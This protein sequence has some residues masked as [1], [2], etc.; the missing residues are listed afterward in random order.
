MDSALMTPTFGAAAAALLAVAAAAAAIIY[1]Q[2]E[3]HRDLQRTITLLRATDPHT[4]VQALQRTQSMPEGS[5]A[6]LARLLRRELGSSSHAGRRGAQQAV[7]IWFI[8]QILALLTDLRQ[9][10][11]A[12]AAR[13]LAAVLG[14]GASQLASDTGEPVSLAPAVAA[15]VELAGGRVLTQSE[16]MRSET[17]VLALAE[18][19]EA[20]LRP[21]AVGLRALEGVEEEALEPLSSALRDRSPGVRR[22]LVDVLTT[23]G[24]ERAVDMLVPLLQDPSPDLRSQAASALGDLEAKGAVGELERLLHDPVG[25]VRAAASKALQ[26]IEASGACSSL[27]GALAEEARRE[28]RSEVALAAIIEAVVA[29]SEGALPALAR[30]LSDLPDRWRASWPHPSSA[31]EPSSAGSRRGTGENGRS[32]SPVSSPA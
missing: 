28:D 19:L 22:T 1:R 12:D 17:R 8:R 18:M 21:L 5:R 14:R 23:M 7:T 27:L 4:R 29:L 20:G 32:F 3:R 13:V 24:G 25:T 15:A 26:R 6:A 31:T 2:R 16:D 10:V 30:A 11:R 9:P